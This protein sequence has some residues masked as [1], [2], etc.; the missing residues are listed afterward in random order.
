MHTIQSQTEWSVAVI[1][2][3]LDGGADEL[4]GQLYV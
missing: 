1:E 3:L 2:Y 4:L